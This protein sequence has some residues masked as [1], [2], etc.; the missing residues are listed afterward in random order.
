MNLTRFSL[1]L[2]SILARAASYGLIEKLVT[3]Y[4]LET[5]TN[6]VIT[7]DTG[8]IIQLDSID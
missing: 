1:K 4:Y 2:S 6:D 8:A 3:T 7:T 5:D